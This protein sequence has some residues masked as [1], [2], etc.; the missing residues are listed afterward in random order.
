MP[1]FYGNIVKPSANK[2]ATPGQ[3]KKNGGKPAPPPIP[4]EGVGKKDGGSE[5]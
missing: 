2:A 1:R 4:P 3:E 5:K